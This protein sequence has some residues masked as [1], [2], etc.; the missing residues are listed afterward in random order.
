MEATAAVTAVDDVGPST[1]AVAFETPSGFDARPG[2][3]V[4]LGAEV[5]GE[6]YARFYTLSSPDVEGTFEVTVGIDTEEGGPFSRFLADL[7]PGDELDVAGPFGD[8]AYDGEARAVV[9]AGGPGIGA[10]VGIAERALAEGNDAAVVYRAGG[11]DRAHGDRLDALV[12]GGAT[13]HVV[14]RSLDGAVAAVLGSPGSVFV[15]GFQAFVDDALAAIEAA[16][17]DPEAAKV[18]SFG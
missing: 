15:Y 13:V 16:G 7:A 4:R 2:Q 1:V 6:S 11:D 3:F 14:D 5:D 12:D 18:E 17:G 9:L 10:A 8:A